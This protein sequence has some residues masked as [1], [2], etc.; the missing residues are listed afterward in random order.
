[1][2]A[3]GQTAAIE[4]RSDIEASAPAGLFEM[5]LAADGLVAFDG[6]TGS[7]VAA[8]AD[9]AAEFPLSSGFIALEAPARELKV[10]FSESMPPLLAAAGPPT[11]VATLSF[12]N[13]SPSGEIRIDHLDL[14]AAGAAFEALPLGDVCERVEV[15]ANDSLWSGSDLAP[16]ASLAHL[17]AASA[18]V[19]RSGVP[20]G[21]EIRV[22]PRAG[23]A[24]VG[25]RIGVRREDVGAVQP[26]SPLLFV[27]VSSEE[28]QTF[29]YWTAMGSVGASSLRES[30]GNFP[31]PFAAGRQNTSFSFFLPQ[32]A[33]LTLTLWNAIGDKVIT[34]MTAA[35]QSAGL[36]QDQ[37]WDGRN[38][39]GHL[40]TN[41]VYFAELVVEYADGTHDRVLR[42]VAVAR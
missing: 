30:Y 25:F 10:G 38:G 3:A 15:W 33:R 28:G 9:S 40:V 17:T 8:A 21:V 29:P 26:A 4:V 18:L 36:H 31:N 16:G 32:N 39:A 34:L 41:G 5:S 19:M 22:R 11:R 13:G 7:A 35:A 1:V 27:V 42:K 2:I 23:K 14:V 24:G 6:N 37:Q 20:V 12:R